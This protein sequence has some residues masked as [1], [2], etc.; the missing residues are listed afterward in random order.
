MATKKKERFVSFRSTERD[1]KE[2]ARVA[3]AVD[4]TVSQLARQGLRDKIA[5]LKRTRPELQPAEDAVAA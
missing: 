3:K 4:I 2:Y 1:F 5:E